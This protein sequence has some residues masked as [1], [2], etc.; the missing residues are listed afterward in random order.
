MYRVLTQSA[1][2]DTFMRSIG[3]LFFANMVQ[4]LTAR[5]ALGRRGE[6]MTHK[7]PVSFCVLTACTTSLCCSPDDA[8]KS[9]L[10]QTFVSHMF[11][12][13]AGGLGSLNNEVV[14]TSSRLLDYWRPA[15]L[16][17]NSCYTRAKSK[18]I[19]SDSSCWLTPVKTA[20][21]LVWIGRFPNDEEH[22]VSR[23][24]NLLMK[25]CIFSSNCRN[26]LWYSIFEHFLPI[27]TLNN[28]NIQRVFL[29]QIQKLYDLLNA[30]NT[31]RNI[32]VKIAVS[33][34]YTHIESE[35]EYLYHRYVG[36][37]W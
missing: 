37:A 28:L 31:I 12:R 35:S 18:I 9:G 25:S 24:A 21:A 6:N 33:V 23:S 1:P 27:T 26:N 2:E 3:R 7:Y 36:S 14:N 10:Q 8:L 29:L 20:L 4:Y 32:H 15:Q 13:L 17:L 16:K 22:T 5:I 11:G 34:Q 19:S 30:D